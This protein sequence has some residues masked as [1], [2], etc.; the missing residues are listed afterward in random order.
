MKRFILFACFL[1]MV[2]A[3]LL[4]QPAT[5]DYTITLPETKVPNSLY[6][7]IMFLDSRYDNSNM[8]IVQ[9]GAFNRK[10]KVIPRT[11]L[12]TQ[13]NNVMNALTDETAIDRELVFQLRQFSFA[14]ITGAMSER[15]YCYLRASLYAKTGELSYQKINSIDTVILIKA[16]DVT[17]ALFR[18]GSKVVTGFIAAG[19][20]EKGDGDES[21]SF[22]DIVNIDSLEKRKIKLYNVP[23]YADGLYLN[24]ESFMKQE[25][26]KK[27]EVEMRKE[28]ISSVK[29]ID[30]QGKSE[31]VKSKDIYAVV[32]GGK[33]FIATDYGYYPLRKENDDFYFTGK[34]KVTA[35]S[36]DVIAASL[37]FGVIGG[38]IASNAEATF[39]MK[40]DHLNGGFIRIREINSK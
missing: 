15:G 21:Y 1:L 18:N 24:Y 32:T 23:G 40:I 20:L 26:D 12:A 4:A 2:S 27:A 7:T 34:A 17:R 6:K 14:E 19:L 29:A 35:K 5:E 3:G 33:I 16:M 39:L 31:K 11:S 36:G 8:G 9:L 38:L 25:P 22:T 30:E 13:L 37:F 10:A 28:K